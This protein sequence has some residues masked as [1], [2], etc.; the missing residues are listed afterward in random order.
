MHGLAAGFALD[1]QFHWLTTGMEQTKQL[2]LASLARVLAEAE[3]TYA[4]IGGLALQVHAR[5]PRTTLDIDVAVLARDQVP[6]ARL[7]AAGFRLQG[8][9]A[10]SQNWTSPDGIPVQFTD[11]P[12]LAAAVEA[13]EGVDVG[14]VSLRVIRVEDLLRQKLRAGADPAR[15]RSKRLQDLADAQALLE[16]QPDL[17]ASLSDEER[18]RLDGLPL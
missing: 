9:F 13:A 1:A 14:D 8:D 12:A 18:A 4:L 10:H 3:T 11:D 2:A 16:Q 5:E 17:A 15:R 7:E 6:R